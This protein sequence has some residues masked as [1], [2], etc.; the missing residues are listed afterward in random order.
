MLRCVSRYSSS[1]GAY[2][3]GDL[4]D[5]PALEAMLLHD[6]PGS[7]EDAGK[8]LYEVFEAEATALVEP[9][10]HRA[11]TRRRKA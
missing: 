8:T 4:I 10:Q 1:L 5:A 11:V 7:F 3:P 6:S 9:E 2:Q